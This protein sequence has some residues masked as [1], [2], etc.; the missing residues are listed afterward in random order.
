MD[1]VVYRVIDV[2]SEMMFG[3]RKILDSNWSSDEVVLTAKI[4]IIYGRS[5]L[6]YRVI[7]KSETINNKRYVFDFYPSTIPDFKSYFNRITYTE[8]PAHLQKILR[9][10]WRSGNNYLPK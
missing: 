9:N 1:T 2:T 10:A 3:F 7:Y 6:I 5:Q 8:L 4:D